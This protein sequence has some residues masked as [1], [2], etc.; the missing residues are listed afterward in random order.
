LDNLAVNPEYSSTLE[1]M[2]T[3][4]KADMKTLNYAFLTV[5]PKDLKR[6]KKAQAEHLE[7]VEKMRSRK[8]WNR[9]H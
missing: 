5:D 9:W 1:A 3:Q 6:A 4:L 2:H 8:G 7:K